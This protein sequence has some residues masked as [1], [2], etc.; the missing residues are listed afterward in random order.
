MKSSRLLIIVFLCLIYIP[1]SFASFCSLPPFGNDGIKRDRSEKFITRNGYEWANGSEI[2]VKFMDGNERVHSFVMSTVKAWTREANLTFSFYY[3]GDSED[4]DIRITFTKDGN[5]SHIGNYARSIADSEPTMSLQN[6]VGENNDNERRI[7]LHEFGHAISLDHEHW[8]TFFPGVWNEAVALK[9]CMDGQGWDEDKCRRNFFG[10]DDN[11]N[12]STASLYDKNSIMLYPFPSHLFIN[13]FEAKTNNSLSAIDKTFVRALYPKK[14]ETG[15]FENRVVFIK[16]DEEGSFSTK[17]FDINHIVGASDKEKFSENVEVDS[18]VYPKLRRMKEISIEVELTKFTYSDFLQKLN[19]V[20]LS[21]EDISVDL[22]VNGN[23]Q[24]SRWNNDSLNGR[25]EYTSVNWK[26][27]KSFFPGSNTLT[28]KVKKGYF[29]ITHF[30]MNY[31]KISGTSDG[32]S[33]N[34]NVFEAARRGK[35]SV[36]KKLLD[37]GVFVDSKDST[38]STLAF[39]AYT[40]RKFEAVKFLYKRGAELHTRNKAGDSVFSIIHDNDFPVNDLRMLHEAGY[41]PRAENLMKRVMRDGDLDSLQYMIE[42]ANYSVDTIDKFGENLLI[43]VI[44]QPKFSDIDEEKMLYLLK[45]G[46]DTEIAKNYTEDSPEK[47]GWTALHFAI[48]KKNTTAA[49]LLFRACANKSAMDVN[50]RTAWD[51]V[52]KLGYRSKFESIFDRSE[53]LCNDVGL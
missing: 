6:V 18:V 3:P 8:S 16:A 51:W 13:N 4:G 5:W 52:K 47:I 10:S 42:E 7:V 25:G 12:S 53:G 17:G 11:R 26:N 14:N 1:Q 20:N 32:G 39:L 2:K 35:I 29:G 31:R 27:P 37:S 23:R 44:T 41:F 22:Y 15:V 48:R 33:T 28:L 46:A 34:Y 43:K 24:K 49:R 21:D 19:V 36:L 40:N 38:G 45:K 30:E 50:G 9:Y